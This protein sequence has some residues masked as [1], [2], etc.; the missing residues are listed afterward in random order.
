MN[1]SPRSVLSFPAAASRLSG[2][3]RVD[4]FLWLLVLP[5]LLSGCG[6]NQIQSEDEKVKAAWAEVV[7]QYK[8]RADL[9]P[10]LV[11]V[12]K[13]YA[14]HEKEVLTQVTEARSRVGSVTITPQ[15]LQN[16]E[17]MRRFTAAQGELST[18][19]SRLM[20]V[21]ENYP[22]L[23]ADSL[24]RDLQAQLEGT[25][26]RITVARRRYIQTVQAYNTLIRTFPTNL[27]AL[28]F[29]YPVKPTFS[30]ENEAQIAQPPA[31]DFNGP[32]PSS[33]SPAAA[34]R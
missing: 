6:Y 28:L 11:S 1:P 31:V 16:E 25:E 10:N 21:A 30:V 26:N 29:H 15:L 13:G 22:Q 33:S 14:A 32:A 4:R 9:V 27:T 8:R 34:P 23:K 3:F 12:V 7:N 17:A 18:A 19:L 5:L 2:A 24:F 20:A